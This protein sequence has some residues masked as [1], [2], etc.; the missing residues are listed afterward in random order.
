[1]ANRS[2]L[3]VRLP[4]GSVVGIPA[5]QG[6]A[7][8]GTPAGGKAGQTLLKASDDDYDF[9]WGESRSYGVGHGLKL[10]D[11]DLTVNSVSN[12]GGD[13]TLP[14]SAALVQSVVGNIESILSTI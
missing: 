8:H 9:T 13:N 10:V 5:I 6:P 12:L 3:K 1:M 7:G 4:D 2:I 11:G 14:A